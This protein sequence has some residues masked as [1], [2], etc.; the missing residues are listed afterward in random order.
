MGD[1]KKGENQGSRTDSNRR[2]TEPETFGDST[3]S[4]SEQRLHVQ[5]AP[6]F[7]ELVSGTSDLINRCMQQGMP[8]EFAFQIAADVL[9][10]GLETAAQIQWSNRA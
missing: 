7:E 3:S 1:G 4:P 5:L 9:R 10:R 8:P 2:D 6:W